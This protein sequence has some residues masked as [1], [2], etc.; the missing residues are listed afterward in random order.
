MGFK[1]INFGLVAG[2]DEASLYPNLIKDG[3]LDHDGIIDSLIK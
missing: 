3:F 2:E 1:D